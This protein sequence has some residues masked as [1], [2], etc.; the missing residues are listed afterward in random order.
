[1]PTASRRGLTV[2]QTS[3]VAPA[4]AGRRAAGAADY[5]R[6]HD[7]RALRASVEPVVRIGILGGTG[8]QGRGLGRRFAM[9]GHEVL[10]GSRDAGR[11]AQAAAELADR[12][13]RLRRGQRR[14]R[15]GR[16]RRRRRPVRGARRPARLARR[17]ARGHGR[18]R[19]REPARLRQAGPLPARGPGRVRRPGGAA[20]PARLHRG[21]RVPQRQRPAAGRPVGDRTSPATSSSSARTATSSPA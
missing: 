3:R 7:P 10:L 6:D 5:H 20:D 19:L 16:A 8:P 15:P 12:R 14:R 17:R 9:A 11:A 18:R 4:V 1:M 21:R 13:E 2:V